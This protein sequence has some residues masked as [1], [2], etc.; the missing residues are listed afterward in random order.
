MSFGSGKLI[1]IDK[2][3][4]IIGIRFPYS[5]AMRLLVRELPGRT[6]DP[7][8]KTWM[9][10]YEHV[11]V[12]RLALFPQGFREVEGTLVSAPEPVVVTRS[13]TKVEADPL[14]VAEVNQQIAS[15]LQR[16]FPFELRVV[17]Q[18]V[19][20][21]RSSRGI[22]YMTLADPQAE[23]GA[24]PPA[25]IEAVAFP[26]VVGRLDTRL[27]Q[28]GEELEAG[29]F[30]CW[31]VRVSMFQGAGR[32]QLNVV[33]IDEQWV[34]SRLEDKR[35]EVVAALRK[36]GLLGLNEQLDMPALPLRVALMTSVGSDAWHDVCS[37]LRDSGWPFVVIPVDIRVQGSECVPTVLAALE[38]LGRRGDDFDVCVITRGG[39][40]RADLAAFDDLE[41]GRAVA[42]AEFKIIT[43][44]G[45]EQDRSVLDEVALSL[46]TPTAAAAYL[47]DLIS[48]EAASLHDAAYALS[49]HT[50]QHLRLELS[51]LES[52][53][54]RVRLGVRHSLRRAYME[55]R[56]DAAR[57]PALARQL[58]RRAEQADYSRSQR[59]ARGAGSQA[60]SVRAELRELGVHIQLSDPRRLLKRGY[61]ILRGPDGRVVSAAGAVPARQL[62]S[63]EM[64]DG[65]LKL[66][67]EEIELKDNTSN[68]NNS[69]SSD[70]D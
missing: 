28:L 50:R 38:L 68:L 21:T 40:S 59:L 7:S 66:R 3:A 65:S 23:A 43:A 19:A 1:I 11:E 10:P 9:V 46:R 33:D 64:H 15:A 69:G 51:R 17:A 4:D 36:E 44:I 27:A 32:L 12:V 61:S 52:S 20:F 47:V 22:I 5:N 42:R 56:Q 63:A 55:L 62:L 31:K 8:T 54:A 25:R 53:R 29:L 6:Y 45:H 26:G 48:H 35:K 49:R 34:I 39:G 37:T 57:I 16:A 24:S 2:A 18:V 14:S 41:L 70:G 58:L 67:V 13:D 60:V 30:M